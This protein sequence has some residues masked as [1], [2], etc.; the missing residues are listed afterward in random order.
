MPNQIDMAI[1]KIEDALPNEAKM[2][3]LCALASI[4]VESVCG[5]QDSNN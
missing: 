4:T 1:R 2:E 5:I 3:L